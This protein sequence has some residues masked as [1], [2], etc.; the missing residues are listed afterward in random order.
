MSFDYEALYRTKEAALGAPTAQI[1]DYFERM[2]PRA[3]RVL[4][5]GCGQGRDALFLARLG[6]EVLGIDSAPSGIAQLDQAAKADGLNVRALCVDA[7]HYIP[8]QQFDVL[9]FDRVLHMLAKHER[10]QLIRT[11]VDALNPDGHVV[12]ADEPSNIPALESALHGTGRHWHVNLKKRGY[13]FVQA[14]PAFS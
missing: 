8:D 10:D 2:I 6:F 5:V 4:D 7:L 1:C 13:L 9:L 11:L 12:I 14:A 3:G